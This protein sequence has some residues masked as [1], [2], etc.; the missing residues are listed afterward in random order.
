MQDKTANKGR[1]RK[2]STTL[3]FRYPIARR[4][5]LEVIAEER[6]VDLSDV[7]RQ[8]ADEFIERYVRDGRAA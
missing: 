4:R 3:A 2:T 1:A 6:T 8:A 7:L 5:V